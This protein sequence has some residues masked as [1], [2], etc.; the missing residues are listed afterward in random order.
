M[1]RHPLP[2]G[3]IRTPAASA[4]RAVPRPSVPAPRPRRRAKFLGAGGH[5][6]G[7][8]IE[9]VRTSDGRAL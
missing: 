8:S 4:L 2:D 9:D 7:A 6:T 3:V 1:V 5:E